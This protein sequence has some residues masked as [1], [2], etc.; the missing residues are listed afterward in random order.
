MVITTVS[1]LGVRIMRRIFL[2]ILLLLLS[3][4]AFAWQPK[5]VADG[6]SSQTV[7][8]YTPPNIEAG[9]SGASA[10]QVK[11]TGTGVMSVSFSRFLSLS[12][13]DA[14]LPYHAKISTQPYYALADS[15]Y[16]L[17]AGETLFID[18]IPANKWPHAACIRRS[19]T[20][21]SSTS[22]KVLWK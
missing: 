13:W 8:F 9:A 17:A 12:A 21:L 5:V 4:P 3:S 15:F 18:D 6:T 10:V 20:G 7:L 16:T 19:G 11:N 14:V 22:F 1:F 2:V